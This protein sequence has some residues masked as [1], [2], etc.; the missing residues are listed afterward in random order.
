VEDLKNRIKALLS[1]IEYSH[2]KR[3]WV[4]QLTQ[5]GFAEDEARQWAAEIGH[6]VDEYQSSLI[7][8]VELLEEAN[9]ERIPESIYDWTVG[10]LEVTIPEI[11]EP[12]RYLE[13]LLKK[14]IPAEPDDEEESPQSSDF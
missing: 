12:M 10:R 9:P 8:L 14:Y 1:E 3:T 6:V 7:R 2:V 11:E 4:E 5:K 13:N